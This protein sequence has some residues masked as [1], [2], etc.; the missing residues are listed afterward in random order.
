[1]GVIGVQFALAETDGFVVGDDAIIPTA[2]W[3]LTAVHV[4]QNDNRVFEPFRGM[5]RLDGHRIRA[6]ARVNF[7]RTP[8]FDAPFD[9]SNQVTT[10][11]RRR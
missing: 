11:L 2:R 10:G 3:E 7:V 8:G 1:M 9:E 4:R 6:G 5:N